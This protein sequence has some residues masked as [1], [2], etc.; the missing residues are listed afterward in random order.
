MFKKPTLTEDIRALV[1]RTAELLFDGRLRLTRGTGQPNINPMWAKT[2]D[3]EFLHYNVKNMGY[4]LARKLASELPVRTD[5]KPTKVGL[6]CKASTQA[7]LESDWAAYWAGRL[8]IPIFFHRKL[9]EFV[10]VL[11]AF[12]EHGMIQPG[13][14]GLG[15]GCGEEPIPSFLASEGVDVLVTDLPPDNE[16]AKVWSKT[17]EYATSVEKA[18]RAELVSREAFERHISL[19][20]VDMNAIP[21]DLA[22]FDFT[23]SICALEHLGSLKHG[24]DFI[25]NS[26]NPLKPGGIAVHT[27]EFNFMND[28]ETLD[29]WVTVLYQRRHFE[30]LAARL[31][32]KGHRVRPMNFDIGKAPMD[33]F[34]DIPPYVNDWPAILTQCW[35]DGAPHMKLS[36]DGFASTCFGLIIE[37]GA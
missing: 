5:L 29:N 36:I 21:D 3:I 15:F 31:T 23:W 14:R 8:H 9:W 13:K 37:K 10:Y 12:H 22:G 26:L 7:D 16:A 28:G 25:E 11:Q 32:A 18:Y 35:T 19:R 34:I 20:Y 27:T 33:Q 17:N 2:K 30:D 6:E 4:A 1:E 24:L